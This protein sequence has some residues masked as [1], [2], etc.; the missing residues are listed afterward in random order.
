VNDGGESF[1]SEI[2]AACRK[3]EEKGLVLV[4]NGFYRVSAPDS[5]VVGDSLAGFLDFKDHGVPDKLQYEYTGS[6]YEFRRRIP[7]TGNSNTRFGASQANCETTVVAGNT[8]DY[9]FVHGQSIAG[10]GYSFVSAS[11]EAVMN[12]QQP[13]RD[14]RTVNL[15]LGKQKQTSM[16][17]GA[18]PPRYKT[19]PD[20]LQTR[21]TAYCR[22]GGSLL[23]S[24]AY[25]GSDLWDAE[26][27]R[28]ADRQFAQ[29]VLKYRWQTGQ[30]AVNGLVETATSPLFP[31]RGGSY[32]FHTLLN[33]DCYAVE[34]PDAIEPVGKDSYTVLR[35]SENGLSAGIAHDGYYKTCVL[36]FPLETIKN[37]PERDA[38]MK[39][40]LEF[41]AGGK[42]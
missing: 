29:E 31:M 22:S 10:A 2:L 41:F 6:Q 34:S 7:R 35:Y 32:D 28:D 26:T 8:F 18:F 33:P 23:V 20:S 16:G 24:G 27:A 30:A 37:A 1:P 39:N 13:L 17:R 40:I 5:F 38:L 19:F 15:I 25:V 42:R 21:L 4:V 3:K 9:P 14:Y 11:A 12:G 36:G